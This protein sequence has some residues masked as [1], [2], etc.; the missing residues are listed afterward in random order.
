MAKQEHTIANR[1][2]KRKGKK[3]DELLK[4]IANAHTALQTLNIPATKVNLAVLFETL[5][6]LEE[7]YAF[8]EAQKAKEGQQSA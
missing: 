3:M 4:R 5:G 6:T 2:N 1:N 8:V 7:C